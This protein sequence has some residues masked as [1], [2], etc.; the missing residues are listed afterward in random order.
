VFEIGTPTQE[1]ILQVELR[2]IPVLLGQTHFW[3]CHL[4]PLQEELH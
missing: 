3:P 1:A 2:V 4:V